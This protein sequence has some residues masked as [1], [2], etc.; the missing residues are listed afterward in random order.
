MPND[1]P[2]A[3]AVRRPDP[4]MFHEYWN[5]P[6]KTEASFIGEWMDTDDLGTRDADGYLWFKARADDVIITAGYRVGPAE[7]EDALLEHDAVANAAV[8]GV[9][10]ETRGQRVKAYVE[11]APGVEPSDAVAESIATRVRDDL[12][13]YQ[14]P[15]EIEFID[16]LPTTTTGK[17]KRQ[18]LRKRDDG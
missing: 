7:V 10:D 6:D 9:D 2:G 5:E 15:R 3:I 1:E 4:V 18:R 8:I 16:E 12:A 13:K 14:Y 17:V 11:P